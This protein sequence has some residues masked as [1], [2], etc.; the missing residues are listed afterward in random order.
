VEF[1]SDE[2]CTA[3][4]AHTA[5]AEAVLRDIVIEVQLTGAPRGRGRITLTVGDGRLV[6]CATERAVEAE[7]KLKASHAD[8][9]AM[10]RG[11]LDPNVAFMTGDLKTD[12]PTGPLL[13]LLA[14]YRRPGAV[15]GR[16]ALSALT[17]EP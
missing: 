7:L 12:G 9:L 4:V 2:W 5:G 14:A 16:E 13:A 1:L 6:G 11:D 15:H 3:L 10:L 17:T 8:V